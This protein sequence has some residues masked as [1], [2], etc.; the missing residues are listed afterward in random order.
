MPLAVHLSLK[1]T[2]AP[3]CTGRD[4]GKR[5]LMKTTDRE[6]LRVGY[7]TTHAEM[8]GQVDGPQE[9]R[10]ATVIS[11][12]RGGNSAFLAAGA[13]V[14]TQQSRTAETELAARFCITWQASHLV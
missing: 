11:G 13:N 14:F 8:S 3:W 5:C 6:G 10:N 7:N 4:Y 2:P 1:L 12:R 9:P